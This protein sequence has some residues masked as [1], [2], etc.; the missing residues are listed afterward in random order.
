MSFVDFTYSVGASN[1]ICSLQSFWPQ[2]SVGLMSFLLITGPK[3]RQKVSHMTTNMM[4]WQM[5]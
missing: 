4:T 1:V 3:N 5:H 2:Y